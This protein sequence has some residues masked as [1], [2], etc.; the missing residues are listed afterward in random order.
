MR[1]RMTMTMLL[2]TLSVLLAA[3]AFAAQWKHLGED[4]KSTH[5][6]YNPKTYAL[7]NKV[8]SSW[9]KKEYN[10]DVKAMIQNKTALDEYRGS[11]S[12]V[13]YEEFNCAER[14]KR[15]L[16]G[17]FYE[18]KI[19]GDVERTNWTAIEPASIDE[20][21][22]TALCKEGMSNK[23]VDKAPAKK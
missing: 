20:G 22:L 5:Y 8:A 3:N 23:E 12:V 7:K 15:T 6:F 16:V 17:R 9:T 21:L 18:G 14:K 1:G 13:A 4:G 10:V 11:K 2:L 19:D